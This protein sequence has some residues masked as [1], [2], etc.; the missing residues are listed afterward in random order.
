MIS[1]QPGP[2]LYVKIEKMSSS[3]QA[4]LRFL[5]SIFMS[6]V[7]VT[8]ASNFYNDVDLTW[9]DHRANIR[10]GGQILTLSLD[11][12]SG[13]GFQSKNEYLFGRF[14]MQMKLVPGDSAGTVT[15]L[16]LS[17]QGGA[18]DEIDFEFLGN[19][20]GQPYILSTNIYSQGKGDREQQFYLWFDPTKNFH[21]YSAI[22][23][24]RKI[25]FLVDNIPIRVFSNLESIGVPFPKSQ[26][27]RVYSTIW[28]GDS[29]ATRGG[30]VK[31]D[32]SKAPF[33]A[34]Y[35]N[36]IANACVWTSGKPCR[37]KS[38]NAAE[39]VFA[40]DKAILGPKGRERLRWVQKN[41]MIYNYCTDLKRFPK[42]L[43][44]ECKR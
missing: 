2:P 17:S 3:S 38:I 11:H 32:W 41:Y 28:N 8:F 27:M 29:W 9:G 18:H 20:S 35:R 40:E 16:Y 21:T 44:P 4:S 10:N 25:I 37:N 1:K 15:T 42:G 30:L 34:T 23:N 24:R 36:Y 22:W 26:P 43:P 33:T 6:V 39:N 14:D 13:S 19:L 5:L 31:I 7:M 12:E